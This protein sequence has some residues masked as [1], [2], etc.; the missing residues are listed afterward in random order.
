MLQTRCNLYSSGKFDLRDNR[1]T[2]ALGREGRDSLETTN[3]E[4]QPSLKKTYLKPLTESVKKV[5]KPT[6]AGRFT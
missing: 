3:Y 6:A 5:G 1:F 2:V 4:R